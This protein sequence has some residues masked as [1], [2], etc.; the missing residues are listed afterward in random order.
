MGRLGAPPLARLVEPGLKF[1]FKHHV[2]NRA[3]SHLPAGA[4]DA[5]PA[6]RRVQTLWWTD[7][8]E[9]RER[10]IWTAEELDGFLEASVRAAG[11][12]AGGRR[13]WWR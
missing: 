5:V 8:F 10:F 4:M 13:R 7:R 12:P 6:E 1:L 9:A 2:V 3:G 11:S